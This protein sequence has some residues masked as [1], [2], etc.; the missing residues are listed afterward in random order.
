M[1]TFTEQKLNQIKRELAQA[2][3]DFAADTGMEIDD[4]I[5]FEIAGSVLQEEPG[6]SDY[7]ANKGITD[8][9]GYLANFA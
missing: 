3:A 1:A 5:A 2:S 4:S 7:L 9:Q 8:A 6:L